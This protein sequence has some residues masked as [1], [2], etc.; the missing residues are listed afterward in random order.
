MYSLY[1]ILFDENEMESS[2]PSYF[3]KNEHISESVCLG[4]G[5]VPWFLELNLS[6]LDVTKCKENCPISLT[7]ANIHTPCTCLEVERSAS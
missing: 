7:L 1:S 2:I 5:L 3:N 4:S 6:I